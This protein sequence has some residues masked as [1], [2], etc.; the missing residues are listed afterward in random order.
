MIQLSLVAVV[1]DLLFGGTEERLFYKV[2][3]L[4]ERIDLWLNL[5]GALS[6]GDGTGDGLFGGSQGREPRPCS[7]SWNRRCGEETSRGGGK[8]T[9]SPGIGPGSMGA[10]TRS[11]LIAGPR[12]PPAPPGPSSS[13]SSRSSSG[14]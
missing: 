6:R 13:R 3:E 10:R 11:S 7:D 1:V 2:I 4:G 9:G 8:G 12:L 5:H 14:S